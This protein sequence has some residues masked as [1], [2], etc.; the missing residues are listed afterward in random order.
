M[1]IDGEKITGEVVP[2]YR[3]ILNNKFENTIYY[4]ITKSRY[5]D[6]SFVITRLIKDIKSKDDFEKLFNNIK[7]D[8]ENRII[9]MGFKCKVFRFKDNTISEINIDINLEN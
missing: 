3:E 6:I 1:P 8:F 7:D 4:R 2:K 9:K 5:S